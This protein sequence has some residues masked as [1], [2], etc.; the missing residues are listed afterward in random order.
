VRRLLRLR[1]AGL[2][3]RV[4]VAF[5]VGA[6][7]VSAIFAVTTYALAQSYLL[8][9]RERAVLR[10]V[11]VDAN[12]VR[13]RLESAGADVPAILTAT[14]SSSGSTLVVH[15]R[16]RWFSSS[17]DVG[18]SS[19][20]RSL[21]DV[22][23]DG[24]PA[25]IRTRIDGVPAIVIGVPL[26]SVGAAFYEVAPLRELQENLRILGVVLTGGALVA[27][28]AGAG[29]GIYASRS[30]VRPLNDV[31]AA[32]ARIAGGRLDTRLPPTRDPELATIVG[33]FNSMVDTLHQR[34]ERDAR[35]AAD[36][37]HELRSPLT[38]L[39]ASVE[40]LD[41]R[42]DELSPRS[43]R[44]LDLVIE[45]LDRFRRLLDNLLEL[46]RV[47]AGLAP[48]SAETMSLWELLEHTLARSGHSTAVLA[49]ARDVE[50]TG[51]K[52]RLERVF[53]NLIDNAEQ[54]GGG[55]AAITIVDE[56]ER[57][58]VLV[59][60]DGPGVP[61][62]ERERIF[63]RFATGRTARGSSSGTGL[64]LALVSETVAAH[65]GA[66][67]CADRPGGG[68]RFVVSLPRADVRRD[69]ATP[70]TGGGA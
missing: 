3:E 34:I 54:H 40:I 2:R 62:S 14:A 49:G 31:A 55:L 33:S 23:A 27:A 12:Y 58:L 38:T 56:Q 17:L 65:G 21:R 9:Q 48:E 70:T 67:W 11:Y 15:W 63:D 4:T 60:D 50:V 20:P 22:V 28:L 41:K 26:P 51:D 57:A 45:E 29:L 52:L 1:P 42:R 7:L 36:V 43:Q 10:Q 44:A 46:A 69:D 61:V 19:I 39:V 59:D 47:G 53:A 37:S 8:S 66:V 16:D 32:A 68:G 25:S 18:R 6:L 64:G 35:L 30:V 24:K 5:G 13:G